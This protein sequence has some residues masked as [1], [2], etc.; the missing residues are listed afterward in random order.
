[1]LTKQFLFSMFTV[2]TERREMI[3]MYVHEHLGLDL[4][5]PLSTHF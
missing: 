5:V 2:K 1:M 4:Q 3:Y